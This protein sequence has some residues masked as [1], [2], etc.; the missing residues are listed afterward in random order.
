MIEK[1]GSPVFCKID[2]EG[3][4]YNVVQGLSKS[5][6][7]ISLEY[8][9]EHVESTI[10]CILYLEKLGTAEFNYSTGESMVLALLEWISAEK[11][12]DTL[13]SISKDSQAFGDL[14]IRY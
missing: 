11:M 4:E 3:F 1:Y 8:A 9:S 2:V 13:R 14:Y 7:L 6:K 5:I 10:K 12:I